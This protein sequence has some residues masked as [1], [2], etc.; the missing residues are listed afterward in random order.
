M[1]LHRA[2]DNMSAVAKPNALKHGAFSKI[3]FLPGEDPQE[4]ENL[5]ASLFAEYNATGKSEEEVLESIAAV[6][7]KERRLGLYLHIKVLRDK[8]SREAKQAPRGALDP[9]APALAR[10]KAIRI[11]GKADPAEVERIL[12]EQRA[13]KEAERIAREKEAAEA[14]KNRTD[15]ERL[16]AIGDE[17]TL[18]QLN[19]ELDIQA[20]LHAVLDRLFKR[21]W[22]IKAFKPLL[23]AS[24]SQRRAPAI[25]GPLLELNANDNAGA[26]LVNSDI[27]SP[28]KAEVGS[29][30][31]TG[32]K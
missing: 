28:Q 13:E 15:D 27:H 2:R 24:D 14:E 22:Q 7:W 19:R 30:K 11:S 1:G 16:L 3:N 18:D 9:L 4:F 26:S 12:D 25:E 21:L 6:M 31:I 29:K 32:K 10:F 23:N 8:L 20:K 17:F 5:K